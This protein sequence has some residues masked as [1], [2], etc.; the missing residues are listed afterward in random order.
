MIRLDHCYK[1]TIYDMKIIFATKNPGKVQ[2]MKAILSDLNIEITSATD[3]GIIEEVVEDGETFEENALIKS[4]Y[5]AQKANFWAI[6]DDSGLCIEALDGA[7]GVLTA[8]WVEKN[9]TQAEYENKTITAM[10]DFEN[11]RAWFESA[12]ALSTPDG[13]EWTFTGRVYGTIPTEPRGV[14]TPSLPYDSV[15]VPN[16][17]EATFAEMS[18]EEKNSIS[19][20]GEAFRKLRKFLRH[21]FSQ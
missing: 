15:F 9:A 10:K 1:Y 3:F 19:H 8:R 14:A 13:R 12:V 6:A 2:E 21:E 11:R 4:R 18:R 16:G 20:R 7:P 5:V 17:Y